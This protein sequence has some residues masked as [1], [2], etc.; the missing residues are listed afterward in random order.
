MDNITDVASAV[1]KGIEFEISYYDYLKARYPERR[2]FYQERIETS[3]TKLDKAA[4]FA[5]TNA[6]KEVD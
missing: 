6:K 5:P 2:S 1:W 4:N 3:Q